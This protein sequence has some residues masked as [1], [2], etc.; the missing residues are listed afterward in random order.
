MVKTTTKRLNRGG[1]GYKGDSQ[2]GV[3]AYRAATD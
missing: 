2:M 1:R 3:A